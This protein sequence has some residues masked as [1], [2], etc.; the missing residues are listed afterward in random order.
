MIENEE[1]SLNAWKKMRDEERISLRMVRF[2]IQT[3][4][5]MIYERKRTLS[6]VFSHLLKTIDFDELRMNVSWLLR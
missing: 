1:K 5:E 2:S 3:A 4:P 6:S